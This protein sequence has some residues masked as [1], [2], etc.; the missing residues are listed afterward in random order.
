MNWI[1]LSIVSAFF[2][3][4]IQIL[5]RSLLKNKDSDPVAYSFV[6][7]MIVALL[8]LVYTV[9]T[10]TFELPDTTSVGWN[11]LLMSLLYGVGTILL[12]YAYKLSEASEVSIIFSTSAVWS[13]LSA[14]FFLGDQ[15]N[16]FQIFGMTLIVLGMVLV[17]IK[18]T[19]W[20]IGRGHFFGLLGAI[21][22]GAAFVNDAYILRLY[23]SVPS[24]LVVSFA[25]PSFVSLLVRP[26]ALKAIPS[27]FELKTF[28]KITVCSLLYTFA[29]LSVFSA[30]KIGGQPSLVNMLRQVGLIFTVL[31]SYV[32][33]G[34]KDNMRN[35]WI[36][37]S[38]ALLGGLLL[39]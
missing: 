16:I 29:A 9:V 32:V 8:F 23:S 20:R 10:K 19:K 18:K 14:V 38:L 26:G 5:Q 11:V 33:L 12:F 35:K 31:L 17:N 15:V 7:Q 24:Y 27:F 37:V 6:F 36:A 1:L 4:L 13:T 25:I 3:S 28:L 39:I 30:I 34:E 2:V 22:F 21:M